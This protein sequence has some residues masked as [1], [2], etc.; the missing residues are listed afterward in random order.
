[1]VVVGLQSV[2]RQ[3]NPGLTANRL[4]WSAWAAQQVLSGVVEAWNL[5]LA[6]QCWG[7]QV[8]PRVR[9]QRG[10]WL[11]QGLSQLY[12]EADLLYRFGLRTTDLAVLSPSRH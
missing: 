2:R 11:V 5:R 1:M 4:A 10:R 9:H 6:R 7:E 8:A 12:G 3:R